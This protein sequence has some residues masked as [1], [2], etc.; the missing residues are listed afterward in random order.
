LQVK[1]TK[2]VLHRTQVHTRTKV[3]SKTKKFKLQNIMQ[4]QEQQQ[5][6]IELFAIA[7]YEGGYLQGNGDEIQKLLDQA[8]EME[9]EQ[10]KKTA[11]YWQK[12]GILVA[13]KIPN[14]KTFEQWFSETYGGNK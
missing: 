12:M 9:R 11:S 4:K 6:A 7:L 2:K 14:R 8:K 1:Q 10:M 13:T 5:T 3:D